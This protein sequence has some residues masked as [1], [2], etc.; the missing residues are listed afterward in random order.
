MRLPRITTRRLMALVAVSAVVALAAR[1][2]L[3]SIAY[4]HQS[5][6]Y[7]CMDGQRIKMG[8]AS[9]PPV[10]A[11]A[12]ELWARQMAARYDRLARYPLLPVPPDESE[13]K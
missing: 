3:L 2:L 11:S 4:R 7:W 5:R 6:A 8:P 9:W 1:I 10:I 12:H 13:P